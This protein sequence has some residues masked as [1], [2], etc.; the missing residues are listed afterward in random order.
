MTTILFPGIYSQ[1]CP[2]WV[3]TEQAAYCYSMVIVPLYDTLGANAC[4][5]IVNQSKY[6]F[7]LLVLYFLLYSFFLWNFDKSNQ[8]FFPVYV[9]RTL[10]FCSWNVSCSLWRRQKS[11]FTPRPVTKVFEE[12]NNNQRGFAF[13]APE[14][15]ESRSR[16]S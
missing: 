10:F 3:M 15:E 12:T 2:E 6:F 7:V 8:V 14:S 16:D 1:N 9:R 5:F 11:K 13:H 4:A